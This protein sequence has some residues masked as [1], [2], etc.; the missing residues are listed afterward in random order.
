MIYTNEKATEV[1]NDL[2]I[3]NNDRYEGYQKAAEETND[4]D[5][6]VLFDQYSQQSREYAE[7]LRKLFVQSG[8]VVSG[9]KTT[10]SGK[11]YRAWMDVRSAVTGKDRKAVLSSC[12]Y[13]EDVAQR[14]YKE[15]LAEAD[16]IPEEVL[17]A[18]REQ[19]MQLK[20]AH[21]NIKSLRDS[22]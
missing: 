10:L 3:I 16:E 9:E 8:D 1:L 15:A 13:G 21:D 17:T 7:A 20:Q 2:I 6:K 22:A 18:I 14:T 5:L 4:A 12:E 19:Q 11:I